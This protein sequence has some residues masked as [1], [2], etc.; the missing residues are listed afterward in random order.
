MNQLSKILALFLVKLII[1]LLVLSPNVI[2]A[3][4][5]STSVNINRNGK[6]TISIKNGF[7]NNFSIEYQGDITLSDDDT[8]VVAISR[9]GYME[10]KK[11]AFG[12]RR[13]VYIEPDNSGQLIK[14]YYV[15]S[16]QKDFDSEGKKWTKIFFQFL[17]LLTLYSP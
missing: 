17:Y 15:G 11:S 13:R 14:K 7:G 10:I 2:S 1:L 4:R 12:N 8:D 9:D 6:T 3:Q 5:T 16:S